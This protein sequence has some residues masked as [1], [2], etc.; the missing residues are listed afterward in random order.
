M[1]RAHRS[2]EREAFLTVGRRP[3]LRIGAGARAPDIFFVEV[4]VDLFPDGRV[5]LRRI[6]TA[7]T[8][9]RWLEGRGFCLS[10]RDDHV[11]CAEKSVNET[12]VEREAAAIRQGTGAAAER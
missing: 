1:E 6:E 5:D 12:E 3:G 10:C 9:L 2:E 7:V 11:V 8:Q 4:L